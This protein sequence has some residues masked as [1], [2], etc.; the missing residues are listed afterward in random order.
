[1][2]LF[3]NGH[4]DLINFLS[5]IVF[6]ISLILA[7]LALF[8]IARKSNKVI[9]IYF[10]WKVLE[11]FMIPVLEIIIL[12]QNYHKDSV[13]KYVPPSAILYFLLFGRCVVRLYLIYLI[14]SFYKRL[15]RGEILLIENGTKRLNHMLEELKEE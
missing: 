10:M 11:L 2:I 9:R 3:V 12:I 4:L 1:V 8:A 14:Y 7:I 5:V 15:E 13:K 6:S